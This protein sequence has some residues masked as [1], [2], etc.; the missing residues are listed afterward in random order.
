MEGVAVTVVSIAFL[1]GPEVMPTANRSSDG[2]WPL[3]GEARQG[4]VS[5]SSLQ[6]F[7]D[8]GKPHQ[9]YPLHFI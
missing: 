3:L 9:I 8:S 1:V 4:K 7:V 2:S 6:T 5:L